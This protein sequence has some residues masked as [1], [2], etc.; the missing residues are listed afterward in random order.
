MNNPVLFNCDIPL[1]EET[2]NAN[3]IGVVLLS[4][5]GNG[6]TWAYVDKDG[7]DITAPNVEYFNTHHIWGGIHDVIIDEQHM[8]R[9]PKFY[10]KRDIISS[11]A[12]AGKE[13]WWISNKYTAGYKL[14]PAFMHQ[15]NIIDKIFVGKYQASIENSKLG[16]KPGILPA[17]N[18]TMSQFQEAANARNVLSISGFSI[19]NI[20]QLSAIQWLYLIENATANSQMK[21][22]MGRVSATSAAN[23]DATDVAQATYRGIVGLWGNVFQRMDGMKIVSSTINIWDRTG[24]YT[25]INTGQTPPNMNNNTYPMIFMDMEGTAYDMDDVFI[26]KTGLTVN[27]DATVPDLQYWRT[28]PELF[29]V[30]GGRWNFN[31]NAGLWHISCYPASEILASIGTRLAKV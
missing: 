25:W 2:A 21:T 3:V 27:I 22:G 29:A 18:R 11:G 10:I 31:T 20:Y 12:N 6:G 17:V 24:N 13:A 7:N 26:S 8:V 1:I 4:T 14:H 30:S 9:I 19:W 15:G 16:S 5:G 28:G 23:V